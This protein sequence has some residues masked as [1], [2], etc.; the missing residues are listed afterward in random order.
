MSNYHVVIIG[1]GG[2]GGALAHDL[3]LRG[4]RVTLVERGEVTSGTTG[5]H[6][7]L[8][9]S[10]ARYAVKDQESAIECIEENTILRKIAPGTFEE[11]DGLFVA[12]TDEDVEYS[13][14]FIEGCAEC[15]IPTQQLSKQEALRLEPN[16]TDDLIL[17][18]RIPD[19]TMDAMRMPLRFFA[20]AKKN[21]VDI[22]T[23]T[24]VLAIRKQGEAV[25]GVQVK[26][27]T[28]GKVYDIGADLIVNA[29][30]PWS[31]K[32]ADMVGVEVP[33]RPS[34]GVMVAV[35]GRWC[36]MV[37]NRLNTSSDGDIVVPQRGLSVIGTS[38]W[39]VDDPDNLGLPPDHIQAMYNHGTMMM[40]VLKNAPMRAAWSAAR[41]LIGPRKADADTGR[42]LSRT[43]KCFDHV[44]EGVEGFVTITGGK[45]T[46]L[47]GMA[48][49]AANV[50]CEKLGIEEPCRTREA[51]LL[52]HT[53]Y[54]A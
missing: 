6:H 50:V 44:D 4:L 49:A 45:A 52:P 36:N 53:A 54:Y 48:E 43:F 1:G 7:G 47:R 27:H 12:I 20:T 42:E 5:R 41:P 39:V 32:V 28:S 29:A 31:G 24:E 17:A 18:V 19:A 10:G 22:K 40:P 13:H 51:V 46:T 15:G 38:S 30:G 26:D 9:H 3:A 14:A 35:R 2:T 8:L 25:T 23:Y 33:I 21:G 34:P 37:I 11:N 16:L